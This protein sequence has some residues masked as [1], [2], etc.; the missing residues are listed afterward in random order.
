[1]AIASKLW[2]IISN[3][4]VLLLEIRL[5]RVV[6]GLRYRARSQKVRIYTIY[7][8]KGDKSILVMR[9]KFILFAIRVRRISI[10]TSYF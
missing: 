3:M 6:M 8:A 5:K 9:R 1:M 2:A 10:L 4:R 7:G